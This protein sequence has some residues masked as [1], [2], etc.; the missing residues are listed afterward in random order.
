VLGKD[1]L[2]AAR[3]IEHEDKIAVF[4]DIF[5]LCWKAGLD[6][7]GAPGWDSDHFENAS[8]SHGIAQ[9]VPRS[10]SETHPM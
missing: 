2:I 7:L 5:H 4:K 6:V 1:R 3:L 8:K 10:A 9:S